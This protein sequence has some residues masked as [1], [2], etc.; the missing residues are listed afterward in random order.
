MHEL[1]ERFIQSKDTL[2]VYKDMELIFRSRKELLIPLL[3]YIKA[4]VPRVKDVV[5]FDRIVGNA[6]A[7]LLE[8]ALCLEVYSPLASQVAVHSL[9]EFGISYHFLKIVPNILNRE[10][11]DICAM[12]KLS[13]GKPPGEF[14]RAIK[15]IKGGA[16]IE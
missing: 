8:E 13:L 16:G 5:V 11:N 4:F 3:D 15:N 10:G 12:E 1:L 2:W 14:Y 9:E 7:V 6:A